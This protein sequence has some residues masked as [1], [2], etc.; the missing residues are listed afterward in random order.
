MDAVTL[1]AMDDRFVPALYQILVS[2][3]SGRMW[4]TR[5]LKITIDEFVHIVRDQ[6]THSLVA[7]DR[8]TQVPVCLCSVYAEDV[9]SGVAHL[10]I[11]GDMGH[12]RSLALIGAAIQ[13][14]LD[15]LFTV[16]G[17][18]KVCI[19]LPTSHVERLTHGLRRW[20]GL[21]VHEGVLRSQVR[22]GGAV[23]DLH[24][25][26]ILVDDW[27]RIGHPHLQPHGR[28]IVR[29]LSTSSADVDHAIRASIARV[30]DLDLPE[31]LDGGVDLVTDLGLDSLA[32]VEVL[33][34]LEERLDVNLEPTDPAG[35]VRTV[36]D[37]VALTDA[38][39]PDIQ[40]S[41]QWNTERSA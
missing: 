7:V 17:L 32:L 19:E 35:Q 20:D 15:Y 30:T 11:G 5:G 14:Y 9:V 28:S 12:P 10:S 39:L 6:S 23:E 33:A 13:Q 25:F 4:R 24:L 29:P 41:T 38:A 8:A 40:P 31:V 22:F 34:D 36:R 21:V 27:M 16:V 37:L 1:E 26:G 2:G 3:D 18:R